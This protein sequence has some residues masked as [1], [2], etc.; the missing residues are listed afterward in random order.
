MF[1]P[2]FIMG[3]I[4]KKVGC[5]QNLVQ[6]KDI[7]FVVKEEALLKLASKQLLCSVYHQFIRILTSTIHRMQL[8]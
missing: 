2:K 7:L 6:T 4:C 1:T 5:L 3:Q 8:F